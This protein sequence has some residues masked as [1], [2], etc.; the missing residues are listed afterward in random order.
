MNIY[1]YLN[2]DEYK[3]RQPVTKECIRLEKGRFT[4]I[5][6][7]YYMCVNI[8]KYIYIYKGDRISA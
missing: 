8:N 4:H 7:C 1:N 6:R 3:Y 5:Y 2:I